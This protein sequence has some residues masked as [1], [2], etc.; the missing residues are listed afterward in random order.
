[1]PISQI[2]GMLLLVAAVALIYL[3][4]TGSQSAG[5]KS[6]ETFKGHC[7]DSTTLYFASSMGTALVG[8]VVMMFGA[9]N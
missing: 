9:M 8:V 4:Y 1:M 2:V 7:T 3:A 6:P 5:G